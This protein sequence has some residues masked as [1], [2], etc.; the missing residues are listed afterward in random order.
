MATVNTSSGSPHSTPP[1][2]VKA[3]IEG[4]RLRTLPAAAAPVAVGTAAAVQLGQWA[5]GRAA[6]ALIVALA[7]QVGVN[8]SN[9]YSD[10]IRGTDDHRTGPP[11]LTGGGM[12]KP[13]TVLAAALGCFAL[14]GLAGLVL[15]WL[16]GQW[17]M[18]IAGIA[19]V[20]AAWFYTGGRTPYGYMGIGLSEA[21]VFVFFGLMACAGTTWTQIQQAPWWLWMLASALG[22][23]SVAMLVVNNLRDIPTDTI[24]GK[25]TL[26]VRMGDNRT[27]WFYA[28]LMIIPTPVLA[29]LG[30]HMPITPLIV[31]LLVAIT[32]II[33]WQPIGIVAGGAIGRDLIAAL[34]WTGLSMVWWAV[35]ICLLLVTPTL[36]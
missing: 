36:A 13:R 30:L 27:R 17:W 14:A 18:L 9:D 29:I 34:K 16:S 8:Y 4:A 25:R 28:I 35:A 5:P 22:A 23:N 19:A 24:A 10:G 3:W 31:A 7:L 26:A 6:L 33:A 32:A 20:I 21:L 12:A 2:A 15:L 11:R 1:S